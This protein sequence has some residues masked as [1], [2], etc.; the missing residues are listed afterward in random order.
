MR[1]NDPIDIVR[2]ARS[3]E[4][5][6]LDS[7]KLRR[8]H[9]RLQIDD[10]TASCCIPALGDATKCREVTIVDI[11]V[12]GIQFV[13]PGFVHEGTKFSIRLKRQGCQIVDLEATNVWCR[14][15]KGRDHA[16]GVQVSIPIPIR[17]LVDQQVWLDFCAKNPELQ[18]PVSGR[19]TV[20]T[21]HELTAHS[22]LFQTK[23]SQINTNCVSTQGAL[24]DNLERHETDMIVY[25]V[26]SQLVEVTEFAELCRSRKFKGPIILLSL[27]KETEYIASMDPLS[28]CRFVP[29]PI[30]NNAIIAAIR[31]IVREH[32]D[33]LAGTSSIYS[34]SPMIQGREAFLNHYIHLAKSLA[35][36]GCRALEDNK[37]EA[38]I[39]AAESLAAS[40]GSHGYDELSKAANEFLEAAVD[41]SMQ[42]QLT[43]IYEE[44]MAVIR[45]LHPGVPDLFP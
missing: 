7:V 33:S 9:P 27:D 5:S 38:A 21:T 3:F 40:G 39:L 41:T 29:L 6:T 15:L 8:R 12:G 23:E 17:E 14:H 43:G 37:L 24:L 20:L 28:R 35:T 44:V 11:S 32:P 10:I 22:V 30:G 34:T 45:R 2:L 18:H 31:D 1:I 16:V 36:E 19:I 4:L 42:H 13:W 26:D 25:D